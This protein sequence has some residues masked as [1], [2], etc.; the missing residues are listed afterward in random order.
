MAVE[1]CPLINYFQ[2]LNIMPWPGSPLLTASAAS[3]WYSLLVK[4]T[5]IHYV[6]F[7]SAVLS[8]CL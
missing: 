7:Q 8:Q 2:A 6:S 5:V 3:A 4:V 1:V